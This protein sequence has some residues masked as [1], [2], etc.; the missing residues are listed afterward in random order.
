M[1][2]RTSSGERITVFGRPAH[3]V[4]APHLG[5]DLVVGR[6]GRADGQLDLLGRALADGDA[7][8]A[9]HVGLDGGV[10]VE[11]ADPDGL[12]GDDAAE[13]DH[14][15]LGGATADVD[16]HVAERLVDRQ[17]GADGRGHGL[18]DEVRPPRRPAGPPPPRPAARPR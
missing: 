11:A 18:L 7:V 17:A 6:V 1:A 4:A 2:S 15:R 12:Q 10:D 5:L 14:R 13:G 16:D 8:L 9:A 3:E